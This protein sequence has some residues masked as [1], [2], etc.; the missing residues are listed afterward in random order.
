MDK[1]EAAMQ[2]LVLAQEIDDMLVSVTAGQSVDM[3]G[4]TF[5][6]FGVQV[7]IAQAGQDTEIFYLDTTNAEKNLVDAI[8]RL[9]GIIAQQN[10]IQ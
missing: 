8:A 7:C 4:N 10:Q 6:S 2:L 3:A 9:S 1:L 5:P